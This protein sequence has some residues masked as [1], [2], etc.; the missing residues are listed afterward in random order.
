MGKKHK[1]GSGQSRAK[2]QPDG[3]VVKGGEGELQRLANPLFATLE[4]FFSSILTK[5]APRVSFNFVAS[6]QTVRVWSENDSEHAEAVC[7]QRARALSLNALRDRVPICS[8][9]T[10][11]F[12]KEKKNRAFRRSRFTSTCAEADSLCDSA[13]THHG[14]VSPTFSASRPHRPP[15]SSLACWNQ[16]TLVSSSQVSP[17]LRFRPGLKPTHLDITLAFKLLNRPRSTPALLPTNSPTWRIPTVRVSTLS[18]S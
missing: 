4:E 12:E 13:P 18:P 9:L 5:A 15:D 16:A 2:S 6:P 14:H 1:T 10:L 7:K 11:T 17:D 8:D 3:M